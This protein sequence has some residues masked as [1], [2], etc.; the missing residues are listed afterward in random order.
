M[1]IL[2]N[3]DNAELTF[4][5]T[6]QYADDEADIVSR[7]AEIVL[8]TYFGTLQAILASPVCYSM[9]YAGRIDARTGTEP[10]ILF[11]ILDQGRVCSASTDHQNWPTH[12]LPLFLAETPTSTICL[13]L[14]PGKP[15]RSKGRVVT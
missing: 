3:Y 1:R 9:L 7:F 8:I 11:T 15:R 2:R 6:T 5:A 14:L 4:S 13:T 10:P 12:L